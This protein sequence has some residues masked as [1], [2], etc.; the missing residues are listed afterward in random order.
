MD[1]TVKADISNRVYGHQQA[2]FFL[3]YLQALHRC[4]NVKILHYVRSS[5]IL[6]S[7]KEYSELLRQE[8]AEA[9]INSTIIVL[10]VA[11]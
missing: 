8:K 7:Q 4:L 2:A 10:T 9:K 3:K 6:L 5:H 1:Q 11:Q